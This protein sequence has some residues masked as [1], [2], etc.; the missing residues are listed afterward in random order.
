MTAT[1]QNVK[2]LVAFGAKGPR[3]AAQV[4]ALRQPEAGRLGGSMESE[5]IAA[6]CT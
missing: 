6:R 5:N 2:G 1:G 3:R 4:V